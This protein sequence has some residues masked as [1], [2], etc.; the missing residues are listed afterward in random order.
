MNSNLEKLKLVGGPF[1]ATNQVHNY[2]DDQDISDTEKC[3]KVVPQDKI[4][5][6][7]VPLSAK[8]Q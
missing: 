2:C 7:C 8:D 3:E 4:W 1:I 6:G 5:K